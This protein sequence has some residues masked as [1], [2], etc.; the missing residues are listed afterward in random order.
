MTNYLIDANA[1]IAF[2]VST[3][4]HHDVVLRWFA[5]ADTV[6]LCPI[7]EGA[8][9]PKCRE[10]LTTYTTTMPTGQEFRDTAKLPMFT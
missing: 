6:L 10:S 7:T 1:L 5:Q 2:N 9:F 8:L 3:H 4:Q